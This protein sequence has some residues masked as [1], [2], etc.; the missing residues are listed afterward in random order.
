MR[1]EVKRSVRDPRMERSRRQPDCGKQDAEK[2]RNSG[3]RPQQ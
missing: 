2:K 1:G 3:S